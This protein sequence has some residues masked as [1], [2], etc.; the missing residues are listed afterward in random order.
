MGGIDL[1]IITHTTY[2]V[3]EWVDILSS[4]SGV[5]ARLSRFVMRL[6]FIGKTLEV[7]F[8]E[9][10]SGNQGLGVKDYDGNVGFG[11]VVGY[12]GGC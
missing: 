11:I 3:I 5:L 2:L 12:S 4:L 9:L 7:I 1:R 8:L 6:V 10:S